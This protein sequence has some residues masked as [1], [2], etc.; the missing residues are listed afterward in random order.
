MCDR[1]AYTTPF[2]WRVEPD[3]S[4]RVLLEAALKFRKK[5]KGKI[6]TYNKN[7]FKILGSEVGDVAHVGLLACNACLHVRFGGTYCLHLQD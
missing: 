5:E 4:R 1:T 2:L 3:L 6:A 7:R